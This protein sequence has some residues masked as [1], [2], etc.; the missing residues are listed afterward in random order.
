MIRNKIN[1]FVIFLI[2]T[3]VI[4]TFGTS[5]Y[6]QTN[7]DTIQCNNKSPYFNV[8][9]MPSFKGDGIDT[10]RKYIVQE[11]YQ[12]PVASKSKKRGVITIQFIICQS[13]SLIDPLIVKGL[14]PK[15]DR[16]ILKILNNSPKWVPGKQNGNTVNVVYTEKIP[17]SFKQINHSRK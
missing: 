2:T 9:I 6:S 5:I 4:L 7:K 16:E 15:I 12:S 3:V 8:D 11:L 10:F 13:G 1:R 17:V 14:D